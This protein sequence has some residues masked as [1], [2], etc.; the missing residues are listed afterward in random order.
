MFTLVSQIQSW[1]EHLAGEGVY[2]PADLD[3]LE[4]HL[5]E[6]M[7]TLDGKGLSEQETF[8]VARMRVGDP[9]ELAQEFA[10]VNTGLVFKRRLFWMGLGVLGM[11]FAGYLSSALSK[12]VTFVAAWAGTR[13]YPLGLLAESV[14]ILVLVVALM[15]GLAFIRRSSDRP[16][17]RASTPCRW[18]KIAL[19]V[20]LATLSLGLLVCQNLLSAGTVR[21]LG[22]SEV[23]QMAL[24]STYVNLLWAITGSLLL[25]GLVVKT[26]GST[27]AGGHPSN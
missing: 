9:G 19:F 7:A 12:A 24:V 14:Q 5:R 1:R 27:S 25:I 13:G 26:W 18:R 3:E 15:G 11:G 16:V 4:S 22:P 10:K 23:G 20:G 8:A 6:E 2:S 17:S 21:L